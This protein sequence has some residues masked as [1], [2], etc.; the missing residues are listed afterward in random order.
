MK[1]NEFGKQWKNVGTHVWVSSENIVWNRRV[2]QAIPANLRV[3]NLPAAAVAVKDLILVMRARQ[4]DESVSE[5]SGSAARFLNK[6]S[7]AS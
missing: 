3:H 5:I 2:G 1:W 7:F 6:R 4:T